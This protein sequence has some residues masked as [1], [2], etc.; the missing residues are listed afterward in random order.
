MQ[1][2]GKSEERRGGK[3]NEEEEEER[4]GPPA[5]RVKVNEEEGMETTTG[6]KRG[7][8]GRVS[9]PQKILLAVP[10]SIGWRSRRR[11]FKQ[12]ANFLTVQKKKRSGRRNDAGF[13]FLPPTRE[14]RRRVP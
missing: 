13:F 14:C 6:E 5:V 11:R 4:R 2:R 10:R 1:K 12:A 7:K 8:G 9:P 3:G